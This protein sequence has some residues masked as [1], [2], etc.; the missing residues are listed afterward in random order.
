VILGEARAYEPVIAHQPSVCLYGERVR[1]SYKGSTIIAPDE[2]GEGCVIQS[3]F[4]ELFLY[5]INELIEPSLG[6]GGV[7]HLEAQELS[8]FVFGRGIVYTDNVWH[9]QR[10]LMK[11]FH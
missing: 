9:D 4:I 5:D 8:G 11:V 1:V 10:L 2:G 3:R 7:I 6:E